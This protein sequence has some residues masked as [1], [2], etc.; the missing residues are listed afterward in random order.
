MRNRHALICAILVASCTACGGGGGSTAAAPV[1]TSAAPAPL[2]AHIAAITSDITY[3]RRVDNFAHRPAVEGRVV[4]LGDSHTDLGGWDEF[5][6]GSLNR[7]ISGDNSYGVLKRLPQ[8][9]AI[10]PRQVFL[11]IGTNDLFWGDTPA[12][13]AARIGQ[14]V[15]ALKANAVPVT[16]ETIPPMRTLPGGDYGYL[17][18][19][20]IL[21][22]NAL[23]V[24]L[25]QQ[26]GVPVLDV[27]AALV[28]GNGQLQESADGIH[29][30]GAL[31]QAWVA[32]LQP[33]L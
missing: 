1:A 27:H 2:D 3:V 18:N 13:A 11:M 19:A 31:Y 30:T 4:F 24:A 5:F 22:L 8:I 12:N 26:K 14:I 9:T 7:G 25:G 32:L 23:I 6:P 17:T 21:E 29:L 28:D 15:D 16:L 20:R 33:E 10:H